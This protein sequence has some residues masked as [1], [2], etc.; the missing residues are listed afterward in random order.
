MNIAELEKEIYDYCAENKILGALRIT[1]R[2][3][4]EYYIF[5]KGGKIFCC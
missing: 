2:D 3:K 1:E 5:C 4:M